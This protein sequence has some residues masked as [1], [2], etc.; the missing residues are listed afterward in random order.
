[1]KKKQVRRLARKNRI[2]AGA[3][4][5]KQRF[6]KGNVV[7]S[8]AYSVRKPEQAAGQEV[9]VQAPVEP[10]PV[11]SEKKGRRS[12]GRSKKRNETWSVADFAVDPVVDK[13]RFH[14]FDLPLALMHGIADLDFQYCTPIQEKSLPDVLNGK[15]LI[16]K[17]ST[18]TGKSAVFL[19]GIFARLL[20]EEHTERRKGWPRALIIAP[21]RELVIQIAKDARAIGKYLPLRVAEA[22]GGTD[23]ER[24]MR[25]ISERPVD[26]LVATP[27]RLLDFSRKRVV[28]LKQAGI[29]VIDEADRMLDMGFIPDVRSII[30]KTRA[31]EQRQTMLFSATLTDDVKRLAAQW[32]VDPVSV[33][34]ESEQV[35]VETVQQ[36]VYMTTKEQK[37]LV[38]YNIITSES[39]ERIIVFANMKRDAKR[40]HDRLLRDGINC[41]LLSGDI[42]QQKRTTR[43]ENFRSGRV[44]VLIATDVA[45]RGIHI[46]GV[47][48]VVNYTLP[49]EPEDYVH[50]IGRTGR[51]G[52]DGI[53]I[54]FADEESS[55]YLMDIEAY[56]GQPMP[57]VQP[58][59]SLLRAVPK[60]K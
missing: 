54:S 32:C 52:A 22:Y 37:Y 49:Y 24:Q 10:P 38:L 56:I 48:H 42:P 36:I 51:A 23:Y 18:G 5:K 40:L 19:I 34:T 14:D 30:F 43:L 6:L 27:G 9:Q 4:R 53:S 60:K 44:Q 55:F 17:A 13:C 45:G 57:C 50:R 21:T 11:K 31:K 12:S 35:A 7:V 59:E 39:H 16:G 33:E 46:D 58:A 8:T 47:S 28:Q 1:M 26:I 41:T 2:F 29:M 15:D 3:R 20:R 25:N